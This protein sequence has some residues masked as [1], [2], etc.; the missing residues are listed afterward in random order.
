M[1]LFFHVFALGQGQSSP[2]KP[3]VFTAGS[4]IEAYGKNG[5]A[6]GSP[7][8]PEPCPS[9]VNE[10]D[11]VYVGDIYNLHH[12]PGYNP[13]V[14]ARIFS[15]IP[16]NLKITDSDVEKQSWEPLL[17]TNMLQRWPTLED[18]QEQVY[19]TLIPNLK[20]LWKP[21]G[22]CDNT[23]TCS[24][25]CNDLSDL[26]LKCAQFQGQF[27]YDTAGYLQYLYDAH[28][29]ITQ[30][31]KSVRADIHREPQGVRMAC[32]DIEFSFESDGVTPSRAEIHFYDQDL[33]QIVIE[34]TGLKVYFMEN[35]GVNHQD[36][37]AV[38]FHWIDAS[39]SVQETIQ[40]DEYKQDKEEKEN[41]ES[42][43]N[44]GIIVIVLG[45]VT[46]ICALGAIYTY[47]RKKKLGSISKMV[48]SPIRYQID[49][50]TF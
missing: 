13:R 38:H 25:Q 2:F 3:N 49:K 39:A 24:T 19:G 4:P 18:K 5:A 32:S 20:N 21:N 43:G 23:G 44:L 37:S 47:Y 11:S 12:A 17:P 7:E 42:L 28:R 50:L 30:P 27:G 46:G 41:D 6:F 35:R 15:P 1:Y 16:M 45:S 29:G 8:N 10:G 26:N 22:Y 36:I 48:S 14:D 40:G 34:S 9:F 33:L 31:G